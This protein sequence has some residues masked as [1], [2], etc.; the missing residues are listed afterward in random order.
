[1]F[2]RKKPREEESA[3]A[4]VVDPTKG[5]G[6]PTPTRKEAEAARKE[7]LKPSTSGKEARKRDR[8]ARRAEQARATEAMKTGDERYFPARDAGPVRSLIR[9]IVDSRRL[10]TEF[11]LIIILLIL[12]F[13][14]IPATAPAAT[15]VWIVTMSLVI[16]EMVWLGLKIRREIK[17]R[18]PE[19]STGRHIFYG[20][21]RATM[22]RRFRLPTP[23]LSPGDSY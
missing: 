2:G 18:W 12:V 13:S 5:K 16:A 23:R 4:P 8:A 3:A 17:S 1:M 22:L 9:D 19:E 7:R 20:V 6:K 14:F 21:S 11:F 15:M 10:L